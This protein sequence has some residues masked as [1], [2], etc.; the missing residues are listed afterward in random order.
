MLTSDLLPNISL[1]VGQSSVNRGLLTS[2]LLPNI[3]LVVGQS[4]V[5]RVLLTSDLLP[6]ISLVVDQSSVNIPLTLRTCNISTS[7]LTSNWL[8]LATNNCKQESIF[9]TKLVATSFY[10]AKSKVPLALKDKVW[11]IRGMIKKYVDFG[12]SNFIIGSIPINPLIY[13]T[14]WS[15]WEVVTL[16]FMVTIWYC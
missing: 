6:N 10:I 9:Q 4:S 1:V 14:Y 11:Y 15:N 13:L 12:Y 16:G 8:Y 5:N 2:D 3:S 7:Q